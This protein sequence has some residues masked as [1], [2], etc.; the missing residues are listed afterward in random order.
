MR[1]IYHNTYRFAMMW[2]AVY[3]CSSIY[4][5]VVLINQSKVE[6]IVNQEDI[7]HDWQQDMATGSCDREL[8]L[9]MAAQQVRMCGPT[10][11]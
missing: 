4:R 7:S 9:A 10:H 5:G 1:F 6:N 11:G 3:K 8:C 2:V